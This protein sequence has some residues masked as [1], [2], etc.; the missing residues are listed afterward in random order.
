MTAL[1]KC[2]VQ[3]SHF[4]VKPKLRSETGPET[5]F[6]SVRDSL[7]GLTQNPNVETT[8]RGLFR[9]CVKLGSFALIPCSF[10]FVYDVG[11]T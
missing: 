10:S 11:A 4:D 6:H 8:S 1:V 3:S 9:A 2:V 7:K 5:L